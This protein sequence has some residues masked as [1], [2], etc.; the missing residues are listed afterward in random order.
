[1]KKM[2][3][4][5]VKYSTLVVLLAVLLACGSD[6]SMGE[7]GG[8]GGAEPLEVIGSYTDDFMGT[9][10]VTTDS[11]TQSGQGAPL[12]FQIE[13]FDNDADFLVAK[14]DDANAFNPGLYSRFD[15]FEDGGQLYFCQSSF[16]APTA[17]EAEMASADSG[18]LMMGCG[19]FAWSTLTP[20]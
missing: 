5:R 19:T 13:Q 18:D 6:D 20:N 1:M 15:W 14:N 10:V 12:V 4:F 3:L 11:W 9:H 7:T 8:T 16:D 17:A 2:G